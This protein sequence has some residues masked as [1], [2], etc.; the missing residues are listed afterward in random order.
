MISKHTNRGLARDRHGRGIRRPLP[1]KF[2]RPGE[3]RI[4]NFQ[5]AALDATEYLQQTWPNELGELRTVILNTPRRVG[6][7]V[8]RWSLDRPSKT[9]Y[10]FR[11]PIEQFDIR[12][13]RLDATTQI[14]FYVFEAAGALL[15]VDPHDLMHGPDDSEDE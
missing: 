12:K 8:Q 3:L 2:F 4:S 15:G 9:I 7:Q 1:N 10:L 13:N 11:I 6:D 5:Q 14:E